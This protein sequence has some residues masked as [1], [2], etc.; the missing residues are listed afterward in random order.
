LF[1]ITIQ[2]GDNL[3]YFETVAGAFVPLLEKTWIIAMAASTSGLM[4]LVLMLYVLHFHLAVVS[5]SEPVDTLSSELTTDLASL[6][7]DVSLGFEDHWH[8]TKQHK[9]MVPIDLTDVEAWLDM[10]SKVRPEDIEVFS[11]PPKSQAGH[12]GNF[13]SSPREV[14]VKG[15][16]K[17]M[18]RAFGEGRALVINSLHRW[19]PKAA[20]LAASL[21]QM[22]GLPVDVYM[23]LTPPYSHSYGLHNDVMDAFMMQLVGRKHWTACLHENCSEVDTAGGDVLYVPMGA[24]HSAWTSKELSAHLTVNVERQFYVW[25]SILQALAK[26]MLLPAAKRQ[27]D[28]LEDMRPFGIESDEKSR[29]DV[30]LVRAIEKASATTRSLARMPKAV[31]NHTRVGSEITPEALEDEWRDLLLEM[32]AAAPEV[33]VTIAVDAT[34]GQKGVNVRKYGGLGQ[35]AQDLLDVKPKKLKTSMRWV[36]QLISRSMIAMQERLDHSDTPRL[37]VHGGKKGGQEQLSVLAAARAARME[38]KEL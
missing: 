23:Y 38:R 14:P 36:A 4:L 25:G 8:L 30:A 3:Q 9:P 10:G 18:R 1:K 2:R 11:L 16:L 15:R 26:R 17:H 13:D 32:K 7:A 35:M 27:L 34:P 22:I 33:P 20:R 5:A 37:G 21:K 12:G 6:L 28:R 19:C 31:Y 29:E 24:K